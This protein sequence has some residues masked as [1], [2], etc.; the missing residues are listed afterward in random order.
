MLQLFSSAWLPQNKDVIF[1]L[2]VY[3]QLFSWNSP[4]LDFLYKIHGEIILIKLEGKLLNRKLTVSAISLPNVTR[5][6]QN[7]KYFNDSL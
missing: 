2:S 1:K 7:G 4:T 6:Q 5:P 3:F